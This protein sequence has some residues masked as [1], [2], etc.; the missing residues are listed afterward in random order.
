MQTNVERQTRMNVGKLIHSQINIDKQNIQIKGK[1]IDQQSGKHRQSKESHN[2]KY[3]HP[4]V[5]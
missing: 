3:V 4:Y 2:D 5:E 1:K